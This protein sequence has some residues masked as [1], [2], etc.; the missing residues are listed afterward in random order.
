MLVKFENHLPVLWTDE[1]REKRWCFVYP[2]VWV[3]V[4]T[5]V[6]LPLQILVQL[7]HLQWVSILGHPGG[8]APPG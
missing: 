4:H 6:L 5:D 8:R 1:E 2:S 3:W 7:A